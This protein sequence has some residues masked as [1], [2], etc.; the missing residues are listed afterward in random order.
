MKRLLVFIFLFAM[1]IGVTGCGKENKETASKSTTNPTSEATTTSTT[2]TTEATE[3]STTSTTTKTEKTTTK[4]TT[5]ATTKATTKGTTA[6]KT[7][8]VKTTVS[9]TASYYD[10]CSDTRYK[11]AGDEERIYLDGYYYTA[12]ISSGC[13]SSLNNLKGTYS[14]EVKDNKPYILTLKYENGKKDVFNVTKVASNGMIDAM[15]LDRAKSD[16]V[17]GS[18]HSDNEVVFNGSQS[19]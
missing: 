12:S 14:I 4:K 6:A 17:L 10:V 5:K 19:C 18:C 11:F 1:L 15:S 2:T 9:T 3:E 7:T 16:G 13:D 8:T